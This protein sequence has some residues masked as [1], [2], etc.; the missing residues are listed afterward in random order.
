MLL[1][2]DFTLDFLCE[3]FPEFCPESD[4]LESFLLVPANLELVLFLLL[5]SVILVEAS[6]TISIGLLTL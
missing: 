5:C 3:E 4:I 1:G 6:G 2:L